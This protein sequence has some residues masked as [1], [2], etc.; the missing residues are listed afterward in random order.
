VTFLKVA[1]FCL[2][3]TMVGMVFLNFVLR[4]GFSSGIAVS[5]EAARF[6]MVWSGFVGATI[7]LIEKGHLSVSFVVDRLP[8]ALAT[9]VIAVAQG[10]CLVVSALLAVGCW[11]LV[12]LNMTMLAT[13]TKLPLG[14][15]LYGAGFFFSVNATGLIGLQLLQTLRTRPVRWQGE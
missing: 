11:N 15:A 4:Y 1:L 6:A 10:L 5:E 14:L 8:P 3:A 2:A 13:L 7:A 12:M 9:S